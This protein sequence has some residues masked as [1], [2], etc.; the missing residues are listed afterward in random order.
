MANLK[1]WPDLV[2]RAVY[3]FDTASSA[4][5]AFLLY[6]DLDYN[7]L[8]RE[9]HYLYPSFVFVSLCSS[10]LRVMRQFCTL[11]KIK[12]QKSLL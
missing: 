9:Q 6:F 8:T 10:N 12:V 1:A 4:L 3:N 2:V 7:R 11:L 5:Q